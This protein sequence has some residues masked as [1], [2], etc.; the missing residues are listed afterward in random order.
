MNI[1]K[2]MIY[3]NP[4]SCMAMFLAVTL[5]F[6]SVESIRTHAEELTEQ[7][8][9][10]EDTGNQVNTD[11]PVNT[12][13]SYVKTSEGAVIISS[14]EPLSK[15]TSH[16][17]LEE[18][19]K[20][21]ELVGSMPKTL[22]AYAE[23]YVTDEAGSDDGADTGDVDTG[24]GTDA[25]EGKPVLPTQ[26]VDVEIPVQW[27]CEEDYENT[28]LTEYTFR[29]TWD[30][31]V[32]F[33]EAGAD[34]DSVPT[35]TVSY[36]LIAEEVST[37]EELTAAFAAGLKKITM[38]ADIA[39]T[40]TLILPATAD[41]ELDGQGHSLLRG[42]NENG[43]FIGTM[44]S[45]AGADYTEETYGTLTLKDITVDG[46]T[47]ADHAGAPVILDC[48]NLILEKDAVV[49]DNYNYGTY[50]SKEEQDAETIL[51]Y[52]GG[53]QVYGE[54]SVT[55]ES[56]VKGNF[57]DE[58]GGGV[59]LADGATLYLY[60]DAIRENSVSDDAGYGADLYAARGSAI[61][62]DASIDMERD[63][64]YLCDGVILICMQEQNVVKAINRQ[65]DMVEI[66]IS[67]AEGS[68]YDDNFLEALKEKLESEYGYSVIPKMTQVDISDLRDWYVYDHY[69]PNAK[70]WAGNSVTDADGNTVPEKWL[71]YYGNN[72]K[73]K[74][75][76]YEELYY[77]PMSA[78]AAVT[79]IAEWLNNQGYQY[80]VDGKTA[81][82]LA[83]FEEH[84]YNQ[85]PDMTFVGYG[86]PAYIDF[87]YYDPQSNGEKM[88]EFDIDSSQVLSHALSGMGFLV[89][90]GVED[91]KL[92]GYLI[93]YHYNRSSDALGDDP[94]NLYV[95][96]L[97][98]IDVKA[99][100]NG[101]W[102]LKSL[103]WPDGSGEI[104]EANKASLSAKGMEIVKS[105]RIPSTWTSQMSIQIRVSPTEI[106]IRQQPKNAVDVVTDSDETGSVSLTVEDSHYNGFGPLM[107]YTSYGHNCP[108]ASCFTYS[109]IHM[110]Y[111]NPIQGNENALQP[112]EMADYTQ[113]GTQKYF[114]NL[115][116]DNSDLGYNNSDVEAD[117]YQPF[118]KLM[119]VEGVALI[120]DRKTPFEEY[121]GVSGEAGSN[122]YEIDESSLDV[123]ALAAKI[124]AYIEK[125]T[126]TYIQHK[127]QSDGN[128]GLTNA[129][130]QQAVG[131]IWLESAADGKQVRDALQGNTFTGAGYKILIRDDIAYYGED[132]DNYIVRY[133]VIKPNGRVHSF[134][135]N[136]SDSTVP[137]FVVGTDSSEWSVGRYTV[138]QTIKTLDG[139][140]TESIVHGYAFFDLERPNHTHEWSESTIEPDC[141]KKGRRTR[142][143]S[144]CGKTETTII[145]AN[146]H[147]L[148]AE[149]S[150]NAAQHWQEC[151][152]CNERFGIGVHQSTEWSKDAAEHWYECE[153]CNE[154][155]GV[156]AHRSDEWS[157]D[158]AEHWHECEIC[159]EKF[160]IG[161]HQSDEW[162]TNEIEHWHECKICVKKFDIAFHR[163]GAWITDEEATENKE[164]SKHRSCTDCGYK[165]YGSII[166]GKITK[167]EDCGENV[168]HTEISME[169]P[170]LALAV[171]VE[172]DVHA[173]GNG[174]DITIVLTVENADNTVSN[175]DKE[176]ITSVAKSYKLGQYFDI[177]LY[178][179]M[180]GGSSRITETSDE[181]RLSME[182]PEKFRKAARKYALVRVHNGAAVILKDLDSESSTITIDTDRFS[183]YAFVYAD[184]KK[185]DYDAADDYQDQKEAVPE[186][187][188]DSEPRTGHTT[189]FEIYA[190]IA[191][192]QGASYLLLLF[193][194]RHGMTEETKAELVSRL[195]RWA[196]KGRKL[197]RW[198]ALA[199][200]FLILVYYH[201]IGRQGIQSM[202]LLR[203]Q[204][205]AE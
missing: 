113:E 199:A 89:N 185:S 14:F 4:K 46:K 5:L 164:G 72:P 92:Y 191:F 48:G 25:G 150:K 146:G 147:S 127:L 31:T 169:L 200:I 148:K 22:T 132:I 202:N 39:L 124:G 201:S 103:F 33:Y 161:T 28:E 190:T 94:T 100:H 18:R 85:S 20:L 62:Y 184:Q 122:L 1:R 162:S 158:A 67:V 44:I 56:L 136:A 9:D 172:D 106:E 177:N 57:A 166:R 180:N 159:N 133:D 193:A 114:L 120:T 32:W 128:E 41:I 16:I 192:I 13:L 126:T 178:K 182:I 145:P 64:F 6:T 108:R 99:F 59:Y 61:Y 187:R 80:T 8:P 29:P 45:M 82:Y 203:N 141:T 78:G 73:R 10:V 171:L 91:E 189:H 134:T 188:K 102:D 179:E 51:D 142:S 115:F 170:A 95:C 129:I 160:D 155:F 50:P 37:E 196:K 138:K 88:V 36:L 111:T 181:I 15:E 19:K 137:S 104:S 77:Y 143:C 165:E 40:E 154:K 97:N 83:Q 70:R 21:E 17:T 76:G 131:N 96:K 151:E 24:D 156:G 65:D 135:C 204:A 84:I 112:L 117:L 119:Q 79:S 174:T 55:E 60:A 110:Y 47:F 125:Q 107:A 183:T 167:R 49:R 197:R 3:F 205:G 144:I 52:G 118:L 27:V 109:N 130:P 194:E 58:F 87:M 68:G 149:W 74:Y 53:I 34:A 11:N 105:A 116:G 157:K 123:D 101:E 54:L 7:I 12:E 139:E 173:V 69:D 26:K 90:A 93:Y 42:R 153:I 35:I 163:F 168:P 198:L 38:K 98:G 63:G 86:S 140:S 43:L 23:A 121:L 152:V 195:I 175:A 186:S 176:A 30:S 66:C 81:Y 71:E 75:Y 2:K